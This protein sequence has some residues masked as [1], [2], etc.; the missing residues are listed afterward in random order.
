MPYFFCSVTTRTV[1]VSPTRKRGETVPRLRVGLTSEHSF[2]GILM[3]R[4]A[5]LALVV[6][7]FGCRLAYAI[8]LRLAEVQSPTRGAEVELA[9]TSLVHEGVLGN[10][11]H[12]PTGPTAHVSPLYPLLIAGIYAV[13]GPH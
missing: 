2:R 13:L 11:Y 12:D 1:R 10:V 7:T 4:W 6:V 3:R 5:L 8:P 9:A